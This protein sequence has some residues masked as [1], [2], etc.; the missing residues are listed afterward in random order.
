MRTQA[1]L[2][3]IAVG[4]RVGLRTFTRKDCAQSEFTGALAE[5]IRVS[6]G[7]VKKSER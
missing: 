4:P 3:D 2:S 5:H 6:V 1:G 7:V